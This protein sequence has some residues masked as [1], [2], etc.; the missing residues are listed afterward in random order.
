MNEG[1]RLIQS[2]VEDIG[3]D[4]CKCGNTGKEAV[5]KGPGVCKSVSR[6]IRELCLIVCLPVKAQTSRLI[7]A[8]QAALFRQA[9]CAKPAKQ[10]ADEP[11]CISAVPWRSETV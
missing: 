8:N 4:Y 7:V 6:D 2:I 3:S 9:G 1:S 10:A 11:L 5:D